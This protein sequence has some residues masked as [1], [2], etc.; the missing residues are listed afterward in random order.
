MT[1]L[2][3]SFAM[4]P[5]DRVLP[6]ITGEV[7]P[8]GITLDYQGMPGA[9][10]GVFYDQIKFQRYDLSEMSFSSSLVERAKGWPYRLLPVF[11]N[12]QFFYTTIVIRRPSGIRVGHPEDLKGKRFAVGD[13]QQSAALWIRGVLQHEYGVTPQDMEWVQTR[14]EHYSHTGASGTRPPVKLTY[15]TKPASRLFLD[16]DIDAAMSWLGIGEENALERRGEDIRDNPDFTLLFDDPR[17]EAVRYYQKTGIY[18]PQHTTAIRESILREHPWV[19]VSLMNA[20]EEAKRLSIARM[21][22]QTLF[23]FTNQYADE[24]KRIFGP[25]PFAYGVKRNRAAI[26]FVQT[27]SLEQSLTP[28]KQPLNEIFPEEVLIAEE[29]LE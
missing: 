5:Y 16:G 25:D 14:G 7:K 11:H 20:F 6:L 26:D 28:A 27:I 21:R 18:P 12:R 15:A 13:Y 19:A 24:V 8:A 23:V 1:D 2:H 10:P 9:V 17:A 29:R 3:L 22:H 4:T